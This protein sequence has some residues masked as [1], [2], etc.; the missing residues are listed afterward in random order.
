MR[1]IA[2]LALPPGRKRQRGTA[3]VQPA[4]INKLNPQW[5]MEIIHYLSHRRASREYQ[6]KQLVL[7][8]VNKEN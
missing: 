6:S 8:T 3:E 2:L 1:L 4:S 7:E 5:S